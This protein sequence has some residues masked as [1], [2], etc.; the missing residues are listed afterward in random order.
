MFSFQ[1]SL[2]YNIEEVLFRATGTML[3]VDSSSEIIDAHNDC[4]TFGADCSQ[5]FKAPELLPPPES[6]IALAKTYPSKDVRFSEFRVTL[7]PMT[8]RVKE[9]DK[10][11]S[12]LR[13]S[14]LRTGAFRSSYSTT[15]L[16]I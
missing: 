9:D 3:H 1:S 14:A 12:T 5:M 16:L 7:R 15:P 10:R 11:A 2:D 8:L 13:A 4:Q 6:F